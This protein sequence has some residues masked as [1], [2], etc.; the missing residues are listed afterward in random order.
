[1]CVGV[2]VVM[3]VGLAVVL[4]VGTCMIVGMSVAMS[5]GVCVGISVVGALCRLVELRGERRG[6]Y[7][8]VE[9]VRVLE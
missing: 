9:C 7:W 5:V 1:M 2:C 4:S 3:R 8:Q 6:G